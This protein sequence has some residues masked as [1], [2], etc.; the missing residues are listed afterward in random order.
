MVIRDKC[1][2]CGGVVKAEDSLPLAQRLQRAHRPPQ[3]TFPTDPRETESPDM[4]FLADLATAAPMFPEEPEQGKVF[5][6]AIK[7]DSPN[8][9]YNYLVP[10]TQNLDGTPVIYYPTCNEYN[11]ILD[12]RTLDQDA[13]YDEMKDR[14]MAQAPG[15]LIHQA[16]LNVAK[17]AMAYRVRHLPRSTVN[18]ESE[19]DLSRCLTIRFS[20][21]LFTKIDWSGTNS[22]GPILY[23]HWENPNK[24]HGAADYGSRTV[25]ARD[26]PGFFSGTLNLKYPP[27]YPFTPL[28]REFQLIALNLRH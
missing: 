14:I 16:C 28:P 25:L 22:D 13:E 10:T 1:G 5:T 6:T 17:K 11:A 27:K 4:N 23:T 26:E 2:I 19:L 12:D 7:H 21:N 20:T 9:F 3:H 15:V 8:L 24:Y 18:I